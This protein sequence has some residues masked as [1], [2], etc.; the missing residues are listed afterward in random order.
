MEVIEMKTISS[1]PLFGY[2]LE[3]GKYIASTSQ[4][5]G[6]SLLVVDNSV[7]HYATSPFLLLVIIL[8]V[9]GVSVNS[10]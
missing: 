8:G 6:D 1:H 2:Q 10:F 7:P 5:A 3:A 4:S 9:G